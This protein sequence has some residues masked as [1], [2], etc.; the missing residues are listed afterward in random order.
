MGAQR[1]RAMIGRAPI[2]ST[3]ATPVRSPL[4]AH[5]FHQGFRVRWRSRVRTRQLHQPAI[6]LPSSVPLGPR[7]AQM[8]FGDTLQVAGPLR[9]LTAMTSS[10][11]VVGLLGAGVVRNSWL[12][13]LRALQETDFPDVAT[14]EGA[15]FAMARLVYAGREVHRSNTTAGFQEQFRVQLNR[16][17]HAIGRAL[18]EAQAGGELSVRSEFRNIMEA[19]VR[20]PGAQ[21]ALGTT[22]WDFVI[23]RAL[24]DEG[25]DND[26]VHLH[27][28]CEAGRGLYL[29]TEVAEE[30]Y[31]TQT[32]RAS[33]V[34]SRGTLLRTMQRATHL[35][36]YGLALSPLDAELGQVLASGM[37]GS[38]IREV[39]I[40]DP[41]YPAVA[42]RLAGL[43][44]FGSAP[45]QVVG[46]HP[47]DLGR[48][49]TYARDDVES[50]TAR[51][52]GSCAES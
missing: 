22:N 24:K 47:L 9:T 36:L 50:E 27:G 45:V 35:V 38:T 17:R 11:F 7:G 18:L 44:D 21:V 8:A 13:V 12:P 14:S 2:R 46:T 32:E 10:D 34:G 39:L 26:V 33:L 37:N 40:V 42:E 1:A 31:R 30:P 49:W 23:E 6:G 29:P 15:N 48:R 5:R 28:T 43:T 25:L 52:R 51:L 4:A 3:R 19:V 16:I 41:C 20:R